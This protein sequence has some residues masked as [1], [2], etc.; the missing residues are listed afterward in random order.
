MSATDD[1][2][3]S[4]RGMTEFEQSLS[5]LMKACREEFENAAEQIT[6]CG[7]L[8]Q[9]TYLDDKNTQEVRGMVDGE[10]ADL[11]AKIR[12]LVKATDES[13]G[14]VSANDKAIGVQYDEFGNR[15]TRITPSSKA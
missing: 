15:T 3:M 7:D 6:G 10:L 2:L 12:E 4:Q 9:E 5:E 11:D 8:G 13:A 14:L 1:Y